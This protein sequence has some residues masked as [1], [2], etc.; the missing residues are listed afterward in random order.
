MSG[1]SHG[2]SWVERRVMAAWCAALMAVTTVVAPAGAITGGD[3]VEP[4]SWP[5]LVALGLANFSVR[6]RLGVAHP[7][8]NPNPNLAH[9]VDVE[10]VQPLE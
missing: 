1:T 7:T 8:P 6:V 9:G 3:A 2:R 5:N 4:G 10:A